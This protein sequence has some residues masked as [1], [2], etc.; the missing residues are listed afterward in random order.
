MW[1]VCQ[2]RGLLPGWAPVSMATRC[3][4]FHHKAVFGCS[5][6]NRIYLPGTLSQS[7]ALGS[8]HLSLPTACLLNTGKH[9]TR[10]PLSPTTT[11]AP[12]T[13]SSTS[14]HLHSL[15]LRNLYHQLFSLHARGL[16]QSDK[17]QAGCFLSLVVLP[18]SDIIVGTLQIHTWGNKHIWSVRCEHC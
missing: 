16:V 15:V 8:V 4:F 14:T 7:P 9:E 5:K 2:H 17:D 12:S 10:A 1:S 3:R 11:T 13:S 18:S 6:G